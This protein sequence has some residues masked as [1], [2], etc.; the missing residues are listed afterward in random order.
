MKRILLTGLLIICMF[1]FSA[2]AQITITNADI[3]V[4]GN[5]V[6]RAV[7]E[8]T[9]ISPGNAG[10]NQ[11]WDFSNL[12]TTKYDS[13]EYIP[14]Q[15]V[16]GYE[17]YPE[18]N[19]VAKHYNG[20]QEFNHSYNFI[21]SSTGGLQWVGDENFV[22][23]F[24]S[25]TLNM[26]SSYYPAPYDLPLPFTYGN[27]SSEDFVMQWYWATRNAGALIDSNWRISHMSRNMLADAS[28]TLITPDG[29]FPVIRVKE[30]IT[31]HDS[32]YNYTA[33]NWVLQSDTTYS[34]TQYRWYANDYG[35][36]GYYEVEDGKGNG[37]TFFKSE[38]IVG[39]KDVRNKPVVT[40]Y[41]NPAQSMIMI[42]TKAQI[43]KV[44][45]Y[46]SE[47]TLKMIIN[48]SENIDINELSAG[49]YIAKVYT[50]QGITSATFLKQ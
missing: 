34:W 11:V 20:P 36:V 10:L 47:G 27:T 31:S 38:T 5:L 40:I 14:S 49:L 43:N 13:A 4:I 35:E 26:H 25:Y 19:M 32:S 45:I 22:T 15:G 28:G 12:V 44:E 30:I 33:N 39:I 1:S 24:G 16:P 21:K 7:D 3:P 29:S 42:D 41:P 8:V 37:F 17:K 23:I 18:A 6:V 48:N 2:R 50:M 46:N 9:P